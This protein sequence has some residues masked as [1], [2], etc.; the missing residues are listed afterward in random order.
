MPVHRTHPVGHVLAATL[1]LLILE[2]V[3][4]VDLS[5]WYML[6]IYGITVGG[7]TWYARP[8]LR[9]LSK[10]ALATL[11]GAFAVSM[12][13]VVVAA[14]LSNDPRVVIV[15]SLFPTLSG[16]AAALTLLPVSRSTRESPARELEGWGL[17][18]VLLGAGSLLGA[19]HWISVEHWAAFGDETIYLAQS[20]WMDWSHIG[21][22]MEPELADFFRNRRAEYGNGQIFT[23]YPPGWP[24]LLALF[25]SAG[26]EWWS[27]VILGTVSVGLAYAI[28]ARVHSCAAAVMAATLLATSQQ[29]LMA[30]AGYMSHAASI[31][32]SLA[33]MLLLLVAEQ[34]RGTGRLPTWVMAGAC[35]GFVVTTRPLTGLALG[36]SIA[37][38]ALLRLEYRNSATLARFFSGLI[39]GGLIPG[40]LLLAHNVAVYG[41]MLTVGYSAVSG[42]VY[43]LGYGARGVTTLDENLVRVPVVSEFTPRRAMWH[44]FERLAGVNIAFVPIGLLLPIAA[45]AVA[46]G[47]RIDWRTVAIFLLLPLAHLL[48]WYGGLRLYVELLPFV[49]IGLAVILAELRRAR[50][51]LAQ[52]AFGTLITGSLLMML[53]WPRGDHQDARRWSQSSY[54]RDM[55]VTLE[56][57]A[58]ADSLGAVHGSVL[59][60]VRDRSGFD[61]LFTTL[62]M[63]NGEEFEGPVL[64]ARDRGELNARLVQR[65]PARTAFLVEDA[66]RGQPALFSRLDAN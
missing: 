17:L 52:A 33:A 48:Y 5:R 34:Q 11:A 10:R 57:M 21:W 29:F 41:D 66:G 3:S 42:D 16:W 9:D 59:L 50:Q 13:L 23:M 65:F 37:L 7:A 61:N 24:A 25:R 43:D 32:A 54:S 14:V 20:R 63:F 56:T 4:T 38:W 19:T 64:V 12:G 44:L 49:L 18:A 31:C 8:I 58:R 6:A 47:I 2:F 55:P 22:P 45:V 36:S 39:A 26:L 53:P 30:H 40:A 62:F 28:A 60:F 35:L 51:G 27:V 15:D 1:L 46:L